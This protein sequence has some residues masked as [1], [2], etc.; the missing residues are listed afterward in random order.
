[1]KFQ[2]L[3]IPP[4]FGDEDKDFLAR[5]LY[6]VLL[7]FLAILVFLVLIMFLI[8]QYKLAPV[9]GILFIIYLP[10][11]WFL[12]RGHLQLTSIWALLIILGR[13]LTSCSLA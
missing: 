8:G 6:I 13:P 7:A 12:H 2:R 3:F 11:F 10:T 1:M 5:V 9:L 4:S